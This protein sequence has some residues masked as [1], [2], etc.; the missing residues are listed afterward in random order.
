MKIYGDF[1]RRS[2]R[3]IEACFLVLLIAL[4]GC[5]GSSSGD[6]DTMTPPGTSDSGGS[7]GSASVTD[8]DDDGNTDIDLTRLTEALD[9][10]P[11]GAL[12]DA[13]LNDLLFM[14]EEEK[15]A[16]DVYRALYDL[17]DLSMFENI[18][19]SE[20]SHTAAV[21]LLLDRYELADPAD[22]RADGDFQNTDLQQ[23]Y[24]ALVARG[25]AS[26][27]DALYVGAA[28]EELD[29]A[30]LDNAI[31]RLDNNDDIALVYENLQKG[32]RNHL[33]AF[34]RQIV[35]AGGSYSPEYLSQEAFDD[36]VNSDFERG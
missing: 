36:V 6:D 26:L 33:R 8:T 35:D 20:D 30:D 17:H 19:S 21:K 7:A 14:R 1:Y 2:I 15:L 3:L 5:G 31:G 25:T 29:I 18:A 13:E 11:I 34:Y 32:S 27:L 9:G 22:G 23:L 12:T 24:D 10:L 16:G 4:T 28:I